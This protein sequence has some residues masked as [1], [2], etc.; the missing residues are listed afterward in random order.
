[1]QRSFPREE[2]KERRLGV[3]TATIGTSVSVEKLVNETLNTFSNK[4]DFL[5]VLTPQENAV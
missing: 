4:T 2:R 5:C 3:I 1:M